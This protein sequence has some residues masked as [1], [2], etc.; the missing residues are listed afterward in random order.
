MRFRGDKFHE[1]VSEAKALMGSYSAYELFAIP[2][3]GKVIYWFSGR[4]AR[5]KRVFNEINALFQ[6]V[7]DEHLR[8]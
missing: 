5:L 4:E 2:F 1:L 3:V 6:D 7:I 8:P